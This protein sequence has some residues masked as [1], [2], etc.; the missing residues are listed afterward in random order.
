MKPGPENAES[1]SKESRH[2]ILLLVPIVL[3]PTIGTLSALW[4]W[5]GSFGS[6]IYALCKAVLYGLP[7]LYWLKLS[8]ERR[9]AMRCDTRSLLAGLGSGAVIGG[10]I[11]GL[12]HAG[13]GHSTNTDSLVAAVEGNG[14]D[15]LVKFWL[16]GIW[17]CVGNSFLEEFVF[18]WFV[19][20]RLH[21]IGLKTIMVVPISALIFTLH[22]VF[23]L[24]AYFNVTL[25]VLGS[26]GVFIGGMLWSVLRMKSSSLTPG[27][28]S[29][30]IVDLAIILVGASVLELWPHG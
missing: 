30:A 24:S 22:H 10:V 18:R 11:L 17:L 4:L 26:A 9:P 6:S 14:L 15:D 1:R 3:A 23:V 29:H 21:G 2:S 5:P 28:L 8:P 7:F 13:L 25:T 12:W 19:D 27:W 20:G 16:F